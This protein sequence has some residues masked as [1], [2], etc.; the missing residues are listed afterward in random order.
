MNIIKSRFVFNKQQRSGIFFLVTFILI[1]QTL[2]FFIDFA[3]DENPTVNKQLVLLQNEIDSLKQVEIENRKPKLF[4]FNPN[5]ITDFKGYSLGMSTKE[6]DRLLAFR[7]TGKFVNSAREF[8]KVTQISDSLLTAISPYFKFPD[9]VTNR[10][11]QY[12]KLNFTSSAVK[13]SIEKEDLNTATAEDLKKVY[14]IGEKRS[15]TIINYRKRL[16]G[17]S[18]KEQLYE[19]YGL[20]ADVIDNILERFDIKQPPS[21]EK[22]NINNA[23]LNDLKATPYINYTLANQIVAYRSKVGNIKSFEELKNISDFPIGKIDRIKLYLKI[24]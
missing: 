1:F 13:K 24:K 10:K 19:V 14:G 6:I 7:K 8:Q 16:G 4:P 5:Y 11:N 21:I 2:Y 18:I 12:K 22:I 17:F 20:E 3:E 23:S 9:W 15:K